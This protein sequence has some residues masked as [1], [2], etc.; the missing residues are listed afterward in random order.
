M[1]GKLPFQNFKDDVREKPVV[2][3]F[4]IN[5]RDAKPLGLIFEM[6]RDMGSS[7]HSREG[8]NSGSDL[9]SVSSGKLHCSIA[10]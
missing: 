2:E 8:V 5:K 7:L 9:K 10:C 6:Q 1:L 4:V 3:L